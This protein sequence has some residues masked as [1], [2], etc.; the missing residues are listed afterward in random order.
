MRIILFLLLHE[1]A[2]H[3]ISL[4][5]D[6]ITKWEIFLCDQRKSEEFWSDLK[7]TLQNAQKEY[8]TNVCQHKPCQEYAYANYI[9][10]ARLSKNSSIPV[11][12]YVYFMPTVL[13]LLVGPEKRQRYCS[14]IDGK[15]L[16]ILRFTYCKDQNKWIPKG[17]VFVLYLGWHHKYYNLQDK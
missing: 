9:V 3:I 7:S 8:Y 12:L 17:L 16:N 11:R 2:M 10:V 13:P 5:W 14:N 1:S 4:F 15:R 6:I